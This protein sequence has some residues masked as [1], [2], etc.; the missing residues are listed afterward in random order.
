MN[1]KMENIEGRNPVLSIIVPVF[2]SEQYLE[3]CLDSIV[4]QTFGDMEIIVVDDGSTDGSLRICNAYCYLDNRIKVISKKNG[5]LIRARKTGMS[6]AVGK[7]IG[8]VD[9]DDWIEPEMY[10]EL[11]R[12]MVNSGCDMVS[13]GIIRD[14]E[15]LGRSNTLFDCYAER[16]YSNLEAEIYPTMLFDEQ[17]NNMGL[18]C[19]LV[20]K[21]FKKSILDKVYE[22]VDE[23]VFY[24]EDA[25]VCYP[26][27]LLCD[28]VYILHKAFYHYNIRSG[29]MCSRPDQR[30][31]Q[32]NYLLYT[33][34]R[35][36]FQKSGCSFS[37]MR[38][39]KRYIIQLE[40]HSLKMLY[41]INPAVLD[42]W[43]FQY[44]DDLFQKKFVIYGAGACGQAL[45]RLVCNKG[46]EQNIV[47]WVDKHADMRVEECTFPV[48]FPHVLETMEWEAVIIAVE[49]EAL[50]R[51]IACEIKNLYNIE[52]NVYWNKVEHI[53]N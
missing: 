44:S 45:Y 52:E 32:N 40:K 30:L 26:Y 7:I 38:Q 37:L 18:Y 12:Y 17:N 34:L 33:G 21:V 10:E 19:N 4:K 22:N 25:L 3:K 35:E 41:H 20:N 49:N 13:S 29:S 53:L 46:K 15:D 8:F 28:S 31:P 24:G 48:Q 42:A 43:K 14:Y 36:A 5:G 9:S 27:C 6:V 23:E 11:I 2:N 16:L 1:R 50:A 47:C 39:L 51:Q